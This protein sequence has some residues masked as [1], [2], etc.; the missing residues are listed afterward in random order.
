MSV[1][2]SVTDLPIDS[3]HVEENARDFHH[4]IQEEVQVHVACHC[5]GSQKKAIVR[6]TVHKPVTN[7]ALTQ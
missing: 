2:L 3:K 4:S 7:T 6:Q 5:T 1:Y